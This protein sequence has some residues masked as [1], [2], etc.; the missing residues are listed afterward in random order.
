MFYGLNRLKVNYSSNLYY[1]NNCI[2][3]KY[4]LQIAL[5]VGILFGKET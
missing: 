1:T 3:N 4:F 5:Y 2:C